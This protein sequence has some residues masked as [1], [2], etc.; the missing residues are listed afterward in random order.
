MNR[1]SVSLTLRI[2][3]AVLVAGILVQL[4]VGAWSSWENARTAARIETVARA[5]LQMFEALPNLRIDRSNTVRALKADQGLDGFVKQL[6]DARNV[7]MPAIE[8]ALATLDSADLPDGAQLAKGLRD[9][10]DALKAL[11]AKT[12][13]AFKQDKASRPASLADDYTKAATAMIDE[14]SA[15]SSRVAEEVR[16]A[17][18]LIDRLLDIKALAWV[19]RNTAGDAS[20]L[21]AN[22]LGPIGVPENGLETYFTHMASANVAWKTI[23]DMASGVDLPPAFAEAVAAADREYF[24]S[25]APERQTALLKTVIAGEKADTD[26]L[27]WST[28]NA[29]RLTSLLNVANAALAIAES[30]AVEANAEA[31]LSFWTNLGL[32]FGALLLAV[33]IAWV[34]QRRIIRPLGVIGERMM[35]LARGEFNTEAPYTERSDE[36]GALG[37]TMAVFRDSMLET[38]RLRAERADQER[39]DRER[40]AADMN[41][42]ALRFD[43]AVG[44]IVTV[45]AS[46]STELQMSAK[47]LTSL[48]DSTQNQSASVAAA[49]EQASANVAS[50]ASATEEL[51]SSVA[52][53]AR[54]VEKSS[55]IASKAV[56]EANSTN[57]KVKGLA[58][59]AEKIGAVVE[60][61]NNI[62][63]QTNLLALNATI[64]AARAGEMGKGFA[65]VAA[66]VKQLAD[67]T[68]KATAEIGAQIGAMQT[69][70][71]EAAEAIRGI[72]TTIET[73][74]DIAKSITG[75]VDGQNAAT[76]EIARNVQEAS[77]GTGTV[78]ESI[79]SVTMAA[80]ESSSAA[81]QVLASASELSKNAELLRHELS[82]F[83]GSIRAA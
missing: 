2:T 72:G 69:A 52:E 30:K 56:I 65:V 7:E 81:T 33:A 58:A 40:R 16:L 3:I 31:T 24:S 51:S 64:E 71:T 82:N 53:I 13:D 43:E 46:A 19:M 74:N 57:D 76:E 42:L 50:V 41:A 26:T 25:G 49:A 4:G 11:Q 63:G 29:P 17:D 37:K 23:K 45:V 59:A 36:I 21:T 27:G 48:A 47:S 5:T 39:L 8:A 15:V 35:A 61:I 62:A 10:F 44:D 20:G 70:T 67:Q 83:L 12:E 77:V 9:Q 38:E 14:L 34:V 60:L 55:E 68:A 80:S 75:A 79:T 66:E 73:M 22:A 28:Y 32:F 54:Q 78:S 6:S 18:G 1:L